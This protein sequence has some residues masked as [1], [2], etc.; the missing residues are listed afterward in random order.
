MGGK[1]AEW[2]AAL[3]MLRG[4]IV[5]LLLVLAFLLG[6]VSARA[7][8]DDRPR[9][10]KVREIPADDF[11][12]LVEALEANTRAQSPSTSAVSTAESL[13]DAVESG[14][15]VVV[16]EPESAP[17]VNTL[18][19]ATTAPPVTVPPTTTTTDPVIRFEPRSDGTVDVVP[20]V[21]VP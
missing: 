20:T 16:P 4:P 6:G 5:A 12:R 7:D 9:V 13:V 2:R 11:D 1:W 14:E 18:P 17:P 15:V 19:V 21:T 3:A 8:I 10:V